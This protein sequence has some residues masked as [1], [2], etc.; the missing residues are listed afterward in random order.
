MTEEE[1]RKKI[2]ELAQ[3]VLGGYLNRKP[4]EF[5]VN[6]DVLY[7]QYKN[8]AAESGRLAMEDTMAKASAL[9]G[10]YAN[11]YAQNVGQQAYRQQLSAADDMI[12]ELYKIA[13]DKYNA[14]NQAMLDKYSIYSGLANPKTEDA[15]G[16]SPSDASAFV[17]AYKQF[18]SNP[19]ELK[20]FLATQN[21]PD[22]LLYDIMYGGLS[23]V[24][25]SILDTQDVEVIS[26]GG[27]AGAGIN[28]DAVVRINGEEYTLAKL[29]KKLKEDYGWTDHKANVWIKKKFP[30]L[31]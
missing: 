3:S 19:A 5:D 11:S 8:K 9:T 18:S 15:E 14:E 20:M 22:E 13:E 4:F 27:K 31:H 1:K 6:A 30:E 26:D 12:P 23:D 17:E 10:G 7:Q 24:G 29:R 28:R 21:L 2:A 16:L 25:T